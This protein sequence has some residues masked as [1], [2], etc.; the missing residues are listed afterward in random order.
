MK[1]IF[2]RKD[3]RRSLVDCNKSDPPSPSSNHQI[4]SNNDSLSFPGLRRF[5]SNNSTTSGATTS[6]STTPVSAGATNSSNS[7]NNNASR[8]H[9][10]LNHMMNNNSG[11]VNSSNQI[12]N[13]IGGSASSSSSSS[14]WKSHLAPSKNDKLNSKVTETHQQQIHYSDAHNLRNKNLV[15]TTIDIIKCNNSLFCFK[16]YGYRRSCHN[17]Q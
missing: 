10:Q 1:K 16:Q 4:N 3:K 14:S 11:H 12:H 17:L 7:N 2:S 13:S 6:T 8:S 9:S 15:H 5:N